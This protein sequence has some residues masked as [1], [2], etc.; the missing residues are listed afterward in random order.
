MGMLINVLG[1]I[2]FAPSIMYFTIAYVLRS[3]ALYA[4]AKR[5]N[6]KGAWLVWVPV[7][8]NWIMGTIADEYNKKVADKK[9][10]WKIA[11]LVVGIVSALF[12]FLYVIP[13]VGYFLYLPFM[14]GYGILKYMAFHKIYRSCNPDKSL[15]YILF[16][17]FAP[18]EGFFL[19][20]VKD[21]DL[22]LNA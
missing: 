2:L 6:I 21:E 9:T 7:A 15:A 12:A 5:R 16:S 22:G 4:I 19:Y 8:N 10:G 14:V 13:F 11:L 3:Q 20:T 18:V 17:I 1:W